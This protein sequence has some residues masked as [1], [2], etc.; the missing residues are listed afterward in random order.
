MLRKSIKDSIGNGIS[1]EKSEMESIQNGILCGQHSGWPRR[2]CVRPRPHLC[3]L[4]G[5]LC[6]PDNSLWS[7]NNAKVRRMF[8]MAPRE[9]ARIRISTRFPFLCQDKLFRTV[10]TFHQ[11][12]QFSVCVPQAPQHPVSADEQGKLTGQPT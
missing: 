3:S 8:A 4:G 11:N 12:P 2:H 9:R 7:P 5:I 6:G 1:E 10:L